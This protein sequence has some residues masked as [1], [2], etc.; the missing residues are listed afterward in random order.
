MGLEHVSGKERVVQLFLANPL[1]KRV[2]AFFVTVAEPGRRK[3][4]SAAN[5]QNQPG[6]C[7]LPI[8]SK[9]NKKDI[10]S[11]FGPPVSL[12]KQINF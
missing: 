11:R 12:P 6:I 1:R 8:G 3:M 10:C 2:V 7:I 5:D 4:M 9:V